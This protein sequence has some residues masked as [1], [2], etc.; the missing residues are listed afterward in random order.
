MQE[1]E[2]GASQSRLDTDQGNPKEIPSTPREMKVSQMN[3][4]STGTRKKMYLLDCVEDVITGE[5][6]YCR[7]IPIYDEPTTDKLNGSPGNAAAMSLNASRQATANGGCTQTK[8][9]VSRRLQKKL[10]QSTSQ[11]A[12]GKEVLK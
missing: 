4:P 7:R 12:D 11:K 10:G 2:E 1:N 8:C 5:I 9:D 6:N 3:T